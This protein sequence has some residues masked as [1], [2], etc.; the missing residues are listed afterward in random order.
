MD[1]YDIEIRII[2]SIQRYVNVSDIWR[3]YVDQSKSD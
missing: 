2:L 1:D 3:K